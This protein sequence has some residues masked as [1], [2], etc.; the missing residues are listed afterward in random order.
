MGQGKNPTV[1]SQTDAPEEGDLWT[2]WQL[3]PL[4]DDQNM[5][6]QR[7]RKWIIFWPFMGRDWLYITQCTGNSS[8]QQK[9]SS[10][11]PIEQFGDHKSWRNDAV[12]KTAPSKELDS[13][14]SG[15]ATLENEKDTLLCSEEL[16]RSICCS[17]VRSPTPSHTQPS[18]IKWEVYFSKELCRSSLLCWLYNNSL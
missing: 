6:F 5:P 15:L 18:Q 12:E 11:P 3:F 14:A 9:G 17:S 2:A 10:G 4:D 13:W 8:I 1:Q 16:G 7:R